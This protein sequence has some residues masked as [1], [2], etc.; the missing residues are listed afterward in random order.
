[1][2]IRGYVVGIAV[3]VLYNE[4]ANKYIIYREALKSKSKKV[5]HHPS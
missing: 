4:L 5:K 1:M 3:A 2:D